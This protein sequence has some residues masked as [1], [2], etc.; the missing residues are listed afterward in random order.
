MKISVNY[1]DNELL[2]GVEGRFCFD[3]HQAFRQAYQDYDCHTK[4]IVDLKKTTYLD[5]SAIGMLLT[6]RRDLGEDVAN[7]EVR[8]PN[9][10]I[11][12]LFSACNLARYFKISGP[13]IL[14]A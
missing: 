8:N 14:S 10:Y 3:D 1:Q 13:E 9:T 12:Q 2:I 5:S 7:I 4:V 6:L 11:S